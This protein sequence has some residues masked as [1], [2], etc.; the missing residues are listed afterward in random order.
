MK[1][2]LMPL[3]LFLVSQTALAGNVDLSDVPLMNITGTSSI[4]PNIILMM[5]NSGSMAQDYTPD[6]VNDS[7]R[8]YCMSAGA[9]T[10]SCGPTDPPYMSPDFNKQYYNPSIYYEPPIK[11]DG[12]SYLSMTRANTGAWATVPTDSF[13]VTQYRKDMLGNSATN[14]N[15]VTAS[16]PGG[17][18]SPAT[19]FPDRVW[20]RSAGDAP[21][22]ANCKTNTSSYSYPDATYATSGTSRYIG[23][24]P[25]YFLINVGE[26]CTDATLSNCVSTTLGAS[27]PSGYPVAAKVRWCKTAAD[28]ASASPG[29]NCQSK[30]L[31]SGATTYKYARYS[32]SAASSTYSYGTLAIGASATATAGMQINS[33]TVNGV[34]ITTAGVPITA[35]TGT[36]TAGKRSQ[37]AKDVAASIMT[38][39]GASTSGYKACV[40][41][42][43]ASSVPACSTF[44]ITL[45]ADNVLGIIPIS[46]GQPLTN[47]SQS[48]YAVAASSNTITITP[49]SSAVP[50]TGLIRFTGGTTAAGGTPKIN[51]DIATLSNAAFS[52]GGV[53]AYG[54]TISPGNSKTTTQVA[55]AIISAIGS[56]SGTGNFAFYRGGDSI[57]PTCA[58]EP[59][60]TV[61]VV[62]NNSGATNGKAVLM[63]SFTSSNTLAW[64]FVSTAGGSSAVSAVTDTI[65]T[66][67][68]SIQ[69]GSVTTVSPFQRVDIVPATTT[70]TKGGRREDCVTTAG[71][72][73]YD[74]EMTNFA[75]WF[76]YYRTRMQTMKSAITLAFNSIM[77]T[78]VVSPSKF[79]Y[80]VGFATLSSI[81]FSPY[82]LDLYP[83]DVAT[84]RATFWSNVVNAS[85]TN[86]TPLRTALDKLGA[87]FKNTTHVNAD[88][89]R[90][91]I[92]SACQ[93]NFLIMTTDGYWNDSY[94]GTVT[95]NDT[96]ASSSSSTSRYCTRANGCLDGVG[97]IVSL[98]DVALYWY[99]GGSNSGTA[100][101]RSDLEPSV[102]TPGVVPTSS[103]DPNSH[104]HVTLYTMGLGVSGQVAYDAT[105]DTTPVL[106]GDYY[107]IV[108][109]A[110]GCPWNAGGTY[111]W[112]V[113]ASNA[114]TAVDDLW[115][116][117]VNGHGKYYSAA[118]PSEVV[119]GL[120]GAIQ[121]MSIR[122][123][124]ASAAATST[125]NVTVLDNDIF[126]AT[127]TTV[128]WYG[129][130]VDQKIDP[131][132]GAV[133][134]SNTWSTTSTLGAQATRN[135]WM[136]DSGAGTLKDFTFANLDA[137]ASAWFENK[138]AVLSQCGSLS[139][140]DKVIVNSGANL[141]NYLRGVTTY[142][143]DV[144]FRAYTMSSATP[145]API[146]LGDIA[147]AKPAYVGRN[148]LRPY[149]GGATK[150]AGAVYA[151]A[152][153]GML[154]AFN[155]ATGTELWAYVPRITMSKM[156]KSADLSY[157]G[158]HI[159]TVD[160][161]PEVADVQIGGAW[162]TVLVAGLNKGGRGFYALDITDPVTPKALWEFCADSTVCSKH[163]ADLGYSFGNPQ[164]VKWNGVWVVILTSG[165]NNVPGEDGV[166]TGSG[167]GYLYILNLATG[168]LI[169]KVST[170]VGD[171]TTPAG[172]AKATTIVANPS[173]DPTARYTYAG[174]NLGNLWRF[175]FTGATVPSPIKLGSVGA[176]QPITSRP[177]AAICDAGSGSYKTVVLFGTGR[178]LGLT[179]IPDTSTQSIYL[180]KD[181]GTALGSLRS[182]SLV[183]QTLS[184]TT[185]GVKVSS[186][187]VN[188]GTA[189]GWFFDLSQNPG[190]RVNLDPAIVFGSAQIVTNIPSSSSNCSVGGS[191]W[192]YQ[193][194]LCSGSVLPS[195]AAT[196][197]AGQTLSNTA[198][199]VGFI[200]L[201]LSSGAIKMIATT[202][203]GKKQTMSLQT[204]ASAQP[205]KTGWRQVN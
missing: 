61:C 50:H 199:A 6:Y 59:T 184:A 157:G 188:L 19:G 169:Q 58:A 70:Y 21:G 146:L 106:G 165:Y 161:T 52:V 179:D 159:F 158:H 108:T 109:A 136:L 111:N 25:Y 167:G 139:T 142:A 141:I 47:N 62:D 35:A 177:Q 97:G 189:N 118:D 27:A 121:N 48:G 147:S 17:T 133:S 122:Q 54:S 37:M 13:G 20:C 120:R 115:H 69:A 8:N 82:T 42:P 149:S 71:V 195:N 68:V 18:G 87:V 154:H 176:T 9:W 203:E 116:A 22:S 197:L 29:S 86:T 46:G 28:A 14:V 162:K 131:N 31:D 91:V 49:A 181:G 77:P 100:S 129:E 3:L 148:P 180:V 104:L 192:Y 178:L 152:N 107:K 96:T 198:S 94:S 95:D 175:D 7:S 93:Q 137:T 201:R 30:K 194:D 200:V 24:A 79:D 171:T 60:T 105:Y 151:A 34:Q 173:S 183:Q 140:A 38:K 64:S 15:L 163:D 41:T 55:A 110:S 124:A 125:P 172:L 132:T 160:G 205:R 4:H 193:V 84:Q 89:S 12:T 112:P 1:S 130:L 72:C 186:N 191:S 43:G 145:P 73:T 196:D 168:S 33:V 103:S 113:P 185:G 135:I 204:G 99:N 39:L 150:S 16:T 182:S 36:D 153:D 75:N 190:E 90:G 83:D 26:Y 74:E 155:S 123:G 143:D 170:G 138:C 187:A 40:D 164:I 44:G 51:R 134:S 144:R 56:G 127:F 81:G 57:T 174:D 63:G 10:A 78:S 114:E 98:A 66:T 102:A 92:S 11:A 2:K 117:A 101:L 126:S 202:A 45:G 67:P 119:A 166:G 65:P 32:Y 5:D 23:G 88:G 85:G 53:K 80:R 128:K 76:T 156:Y